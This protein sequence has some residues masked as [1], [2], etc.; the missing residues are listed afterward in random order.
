MA[1][2]RLAAPRLPAGAMSALIPRE[3]REHFRANMAFALRA[4]INFVPPPDDFER[5]LDDIAERERLMEEDAAWIR[6]ARTLLHDWSAAV[7]GRANE[8]LATLP[9]RHR[10]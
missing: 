1:S 2:L 4:G 10:P 3:E 5:L 9:E 7:G 6:R 8:V